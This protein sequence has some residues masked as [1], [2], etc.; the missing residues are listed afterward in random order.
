MCWELSVVTTQKARK[1][2]RCE[3]A[4]WILN[5]DLDEIALSAEERAQIENAREQKWQILPGQSYIKTKGIWDGE[6]ATFRA[7]P[8]LNAICIKHRIYD[9][10]C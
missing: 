5:A 9:T 1:T 7:R 8:E 2:Y 10:H 3:A 4:E 6:F